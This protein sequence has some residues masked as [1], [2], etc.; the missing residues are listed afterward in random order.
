M[1][2]TRGVDDI[3]RVV[4][5]KEIRKVLGIKQYDELEISANTETGQIIMEKRGT[6]R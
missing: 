5:P 6:D 4:I 1:S 2:T 3:G